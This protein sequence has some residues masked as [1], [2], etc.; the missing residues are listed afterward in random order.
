MRIKLVA[1]LDLGVVVLVL[2]GLLEVLIVPVE[3]VP[4]RE[5]SALQSSF[6]L[7]LRENMFPLGVTAAPG[8]RK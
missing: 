2:A 5:G 7:A 6:D 3:K 1:L 4:T 8:N